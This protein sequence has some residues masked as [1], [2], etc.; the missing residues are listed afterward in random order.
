MIDRV[1]WCKMHSPERCSEVGCVGR[2]D[3]CPISGFA[4]VDITCRAQNLPRAH[5]LPHADPNE[6]VEILKAKRQRAK[7]REQQVA[8]ELTPTASRVSPHRRVVI[9]C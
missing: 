9:I 1:V 3:T 4:G 6:M 2:G 7:E 5:K 8:N